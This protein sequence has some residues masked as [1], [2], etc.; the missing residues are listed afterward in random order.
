M[1]PRDLFGVAVRV[2]GLI[3]TLLGLYYFVAGLWVVIQLPH[4]SAASMLFFPG[5]LFIGVGF[6]LMLGAGVVVKFLYPKDDE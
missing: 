3:S 6:F 1:K 4:G 2:I 5:I